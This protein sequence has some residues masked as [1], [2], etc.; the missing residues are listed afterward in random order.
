M[1]NSTD[2]LNCPSI[3]G[4]ETFLGWSTHITPHE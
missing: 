4:P 3:I 2:H 1:K